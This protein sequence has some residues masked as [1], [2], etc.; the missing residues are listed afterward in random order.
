MGICWLCIVGSGLSISDGGSRFGAAFEV[1]LCVYE[2][3]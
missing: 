1:F 3:I 2:D